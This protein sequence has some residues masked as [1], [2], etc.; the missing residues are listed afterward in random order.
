[1]SASEGDKS[2]TVCFHIC[3][4]GFAYSESSGNCRPCPLGSYEIAGFC[5]VCPSNT[6][7]NETGSVECTECVSDTVSSPGSSKCFTGLCFDVTM[8]NSQ[9]LG[10]EPYNLEVYKTNDEDLH[11]AIEYRFDFVEE[12]EIKTA[13]MCL[14]YNECYSTQVMIGSSPS[15][16]GA[17]F[18]SAF[19]WKIE[20]TASGND[21]AIAHSVN[22]ET[23][24]FCL[25]PC[26]P[27]FAYDFE[28]KNCVVCREGTYSDSGMFCIPC[29]VNSYSD[30]EGA[31]SCTPCSDD[32]MTL[33]SGS[34]SAEECVER[35][36]YDAALTGNTVAADGKTVSTELGIFSTTDMSLLSTVP[37]LGSASI[38]FCIPRDHCYLGILLNDNRDSFEWQVTDDDTS[39]AT[40]SGDTASVPFCGFTCSEGEGQDFTNF[41]CDPCEMGEYED[42]GVCKLCPINTFTNQI[43][44]TSC[45]SCP[46]NTSSFEGA[47]NCFTP[48]CL[49]VKLNGVSSGDTLTVYDSVLK[50]PVNVL[51]SSLHNSEICL[52]SSRCYDA[53]VSGGSGSFK[54]KNSAGELVIKWG[55]VDNSFPY[56]CLLSCDAGYVVDPLTLDCIP[57]Q[58]GTFN[59][60]GSN[61][62]LSCIA[63]TYT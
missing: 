38:G 46:A 33:S 6:F 48:V 43:G 30:V 49:Q 1:M 21:F 61:T 22:L 51:D 11:S 57:Y 50:L 26:D 32:L 41:V 14:E 13:P 35:V 24:E 18:P 17:W 9:G 28:S 15:I 47:A 42:E 2:E 3:P 45:E 10:F 60:D 7:S 59:G 62:C 54:L 23:D 19:S 20:K 29:D 5:F 36:C 8:M 25:I 58:A 31:D 16:K 56:L 40:S 63:G 55:G 12:S 39:V 44:S 4:A 53:M 27:G 37:L 52:D 34:I